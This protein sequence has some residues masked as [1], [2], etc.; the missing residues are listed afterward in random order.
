MKAEYLIEGQELLEV[1]WTAREA[2][3]TE[4]VADEL[5]QLWLRIPK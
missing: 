3:I 1:E 2:P 4:I 5:E